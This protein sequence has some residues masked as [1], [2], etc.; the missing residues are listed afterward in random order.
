[1]GVSILWRPWWLGSWERIG[2]VGDAFFST[3]AVFPA[4]L[5]TDT[6]NHSIPAPES[7][8]FGPPA[9]RRSP[10]PAGRG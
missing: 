3:I 7:G 9:G 10:S 5:D 1:M 6:S 4:P 8:H 2:K